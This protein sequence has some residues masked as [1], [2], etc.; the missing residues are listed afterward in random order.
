[1]SMRYEGESVWVRPYGQGEGSGFGSGSGTV[2]GERI[3]GTLTW[4]NHPRRREDGVWC[5][6]LNGFISTTEGDKILVA[7]K[8][9]SILE[10]PPGEKRSIVAS[11]TFQTKAEN[12][13]YRWLN[14][15]IGI[16]EGEIDEEK[17]TLWLNV[18]ACLNQ[19]ASNPSA[20]PEG[21]EA[22]QKILSSMLDVK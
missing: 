13:R 11:V 7:I 18:Y 9:Y 17:D 10:K 2:N 8:G 3:K 14:Y 22:T 21:D 1:M 5:P 15:I 12:H 20:L 6:N 4:A 19:V 16:A